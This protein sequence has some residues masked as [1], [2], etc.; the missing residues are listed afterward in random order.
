MKKLLLFFGMLLTYAGMSQQPVFTIGSSRTMN[1]MGNP[2]YTTFRIGHNNYVLFQKFSMSEGMLMHLEGFSDPDDGFFCSQDIN[3]PHAVNEVAIWEGFIALNDKMILFRSVFNKEAKKEVLY[4]HDVTEKGIV[5]QT[6]KEI[7]FITAEKAMNSGNFSIKAAADGKSFVVLSEYPFVKETKEKL[8]ITVFDNVLNQVW[9]KELELPYDSRRGPVN[10]VSVSNSGVAY[11]IKKVEGPK[12]ADFYSVFQF[13]EK[14]A[15]VKENVLDMEA[16]KKIV[17]YGSVI[18]EKSAE[19]IVAGYYT[20]DGK[21][22]I[23]GTGFK[24]AFIAKVSGAGEVLSRSSN[25]FE[26]T[27]SNLRVTK[28]IQLK[29]NIFLVGEEKYE[30]NIATEQKDSRGFPVYNREFIANDIHITVFDASGKLVTNTVLAKENRSVEDGGFSNSAAVSIVGE[31]LML[32]YNG[33]QYKYDGQEHK[34]VGPGLAGVKIPVI[35]FIGADGSTGKT[36]AMIDS[37]VGG[38]KG[39]AYLFPDIFTPVSDKEFFFLSRTTNQYGTIS[40]V[41][42]R[43]P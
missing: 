21:V 8:A 3:V 24:G 11:I 23:G 1:A 25:S 10:E 39:L 2:D 38:K 16:P 20:E 34:V 30:N 33:Y 17:N 13:S 12:N 14:G 22:T 36:F 19:L 26:K 41:R 6:G 42:M 43:L 9:T 5:S 27:K 29:G 32:V 15:K 4:A 7:T 35:Q 40:P 18:D 28:V 37:N 31:Q